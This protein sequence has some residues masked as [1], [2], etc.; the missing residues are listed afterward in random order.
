[1]STARY[2]RPQLLVLGSVSELTLAGEDPCRFLPPADTY[3]QTGEADFL[4]NQSQAGLTTCS[5]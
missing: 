2:E 5:P 1:M 3:K 4:I